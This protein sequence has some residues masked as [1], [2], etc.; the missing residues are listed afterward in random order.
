MVIK[1][2]LKVGKVFSAKRRTVVGIFEPL[3]NDRQIKSVN[4]IEVQYDSP[5]V[6]NGRHFPKVKIEAF[7]KWAKEDITEDMPKGEWR[8]G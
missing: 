6:K 4:H 7:L 5:S 8:K 3:L 2:D 1:E